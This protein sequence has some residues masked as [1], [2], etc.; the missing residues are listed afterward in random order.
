MGRLTSEEVIAVQ[1]DWET[2]APDQEHAKEVSAA[3]LKM[4][5]EKHPQYKSLFSFLKGN[6]N[7]PWETVMQMEGFKK[8]TTV[9]SK[10]LSIAI[11]ELGDEEAAK[12]I[13][14]KQGANHKPR[15]VRSEHCEALSNC[16]LELVDGKTTHMEAWKKFSTFISQ[17][18]ARICG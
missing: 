12:Q 2:L 1:K 7:K 5:F 15:N 3:L 6:E 11:K 9:L 18:M 8:H 4:L 13:F 16:L 10:Y 14:E 17:D